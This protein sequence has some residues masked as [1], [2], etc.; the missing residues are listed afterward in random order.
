MSFAQRHPEGQHAVVT[1]LPDFSPMMCFLAA[2]TVAI[3]LEPQARLTLFDGIAGLLAVFG[4]RQTERLFSGLLLALVVSLAVM[5]A[6]T[7]V[8]GSGV[9]ALVGRSYS[10]IALFVEVV[11]YYILASRTNETGRAALIFGAMLGICAHYFYPNDLRVV[12][13]PVKFLIGIPFGVGVVAIYA[14]LSKGRRVPVM[15]AVGLMMVYGIFSFLIGSRSVGGVFFAAALVLVL[16]PHIPLPKNYTRLAPLIMVVFGVGL[17]AFAELYSFLAIR[18]LF[19][20]TAANIAIFQ[21]SFGSILIGGRPEIVVNLIGIRES[22]LLGVGIN[23]Y[24]AIYL[25]DMINL[26]V[27]SEDSVLDIDNILYHSA[28]FATAFESGILSATFW[29]VALYR[30]LFAMPL[31][32]DMPVGQRVCVLPLLL[33]TAW[34]LLYSPPISYNRFVMA[35]GLAFAYYIFADWKRRNDGA[36]YQAP[37][38]A[39]RLD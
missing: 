3:P 27:Y 12:D 16:L 17:Y 5:A 36:V 23:N 15:P 39:W 13:N 32:R 9:I 1:G 26:R 21:D 33:V 30:A 7:Y 31:L 38:S 6:S 11:G 25:Y 34:H 35:V 19:G 37:A 10:S 24:P 14:L 28:I 2:F 8:H 22:P 29:V 18:G 4:W 20:D